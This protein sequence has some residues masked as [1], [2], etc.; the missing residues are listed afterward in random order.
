M[1]SES[2]TSSSTSGRI[3]ANR[4]TLRNGLPPTDMGGRKYS[5]INA[6][7]TIKVRRKVAGI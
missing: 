4:S 1:V 3:S 7:T 6:P 2:H 5:P